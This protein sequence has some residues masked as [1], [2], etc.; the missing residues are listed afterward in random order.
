MDD[1]K[2]VGLIV[3]IVTVLLC[4]CPG[5]VCMGIGLI[6]TA[7]NRLED[8]GFDVSGDPRAIAIPFI[9]IGL[10][11]LL[12]PLAAGIYTFLQSRKEE[13]LED[14]EVPEAL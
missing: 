10:L 3:T 11:M 7:G 14:I 8:Y 9:C 12:V 2:K 13:E 6:S 5:L 4:G 1:K